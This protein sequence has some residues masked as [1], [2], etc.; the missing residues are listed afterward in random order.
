MVFNYLLP[1]TN[2][3]FGEGSLKSL[4]SE[5]KKMGKSALLVTGRS[6]ME[7]L[8]FL[9]QALRLL[10]KEDIEVFHYN[11]VLPNPTVEIVDEGARLALEKNCQVIIGMGGGSAMDTAKAI[12]VVAGHSK[13]RILSIWEFS[14]ALENPLPI[15][16]AALP[17]VAITSTSGTGSHVTRYA[18]VSNPETSEKPG[19][20]SEYMYPRLSIV[21]LNIVKTMPPELT[22]RTGFDTLAHV[23]EAFISRKSNPITDLYCLKAIELVTKYLPLA[24]QRQDDMEARYSMAL[25]DTY[26]GWAI[27]AATA[28]LPHAMSHPISG[29]YPDIDHGVALAA[30]SAT[31]MEFNIENGD[32]KTIQKYCQI[33]KAMGKQVKEYSKKEAKK[34]I[35]ALKELCDKIGLTVSLGKLGVDR[36]KIP[37]MTKGV[38]R[39][40][41]RGVENNPVPV[42]E[43]DVES[44][45]NKSL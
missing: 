25:A 44:L 10:K 40:M 34:S 21:D 41:R 13:E 39:T 29:Y 8:G 33:A 43:S 38:F 7:K 4:G 35:E 18:V 42:T 2:L 17:V 14:P 26:G 3:I 27:T 22:A 24:Y 6:S 28:A 9:D 20:A 31:I 11:K 23:L 16:E 32:Q 12:A 5:T 45:Y 30:I 1:Y 37:E 15:T 36:N 19:F